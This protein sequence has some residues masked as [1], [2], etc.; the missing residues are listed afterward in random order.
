MAHAGQANTGFVGHACTKVAYVKLWPEY[1]LKFTPQHEEAPPN[2]FHV[3]IYDN[4]DEP[5]VADG[6]A[7]KSVVNYQREVFK[8]I[9]KVHLDRQDI[10]HPEIQ[11]ILNL[12]D[13]I[14]YKKG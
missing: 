6:E 12:R 4:S 10:T 9:W 11:P 1:S 3:D 14:V 8:E 2:L 13:F 5:V 7:S